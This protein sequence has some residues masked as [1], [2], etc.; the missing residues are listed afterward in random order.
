MS[1]LRE[2]KSKQLHIKSNNWAGDGQL[3]TLHAMIKNAI[4]NA[5]ECCYAATI[6]RFQHLSVAHLMYPAH[7]KINGAYSS[8]NFTR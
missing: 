1:H 5:H 7:S 2:K 3:F 8:K 6:K 4:T